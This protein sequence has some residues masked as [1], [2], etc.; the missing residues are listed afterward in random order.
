M[1]EPLDEKKAKKKSPAARQDDVEPGS[2]AFML[3]ELANTRDDLRMFTERF[4]KLLTFYFTALAAILSAIVII[5]TQQQP[6]SAQRP[7]LLLLGMAA[8]GFSLVI[9]VRLCITRSMMAYQIGFARRNQEFFFRQYS[10]LELIKYSESGYP[11]T[12]DYWNKW[13][14]TIFPRRTIG[15]FYLF[16][17]FIA[18][19]G[20][21]TSIGIVM[22]VWDLFGISYWPLSEYTLAWLISVGLLTSVLTIVFAIVV[23]KFFRTRAQKYIEISFDSLG[24]PSNDPVQTADHG[25]GKRPQ[26]TPVKTPSTKD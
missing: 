8:W 15:L 9:Y 5:I 23:L 22:T 20:A 26:K 7:A 6:F 18:S 2:V 13:E 17:L 4:E 12:P 10:H 11:I 19:I 14:G 3:A 24:V 1:A 16:A 25:D 21:A